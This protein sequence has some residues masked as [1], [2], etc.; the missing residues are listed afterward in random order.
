[1]SRTPPNSPILFFD[2]ECTLCNQSV[3]WILRHEQRNHLRFASLSSQVAQDLLHDTPCAEHTDSIVLWE[4]DGTVY[5]A[6]DAALR[7]VRLLSPWWRPLHLLA[8]VPRIIREPAYRVVARNRKRW[9]G[10]TPH[11]ALLTDIDPARL[12]S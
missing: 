9:F 8:L 11:C 2:G 10:T 5:A 12:L 4:P 1:M 3:L 6:S 7:L